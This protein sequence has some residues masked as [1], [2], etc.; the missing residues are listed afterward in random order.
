VILGAFL[1]EVG[2][3]VTTI[4]FVFTLGDTAFLIAVPI[5]CLVV[6]FVIARWLCRKIE[7]GFAL[8]GMLMGIVAT[9]MYFGL[10]Y[11]SGGSIA[12]AVETY[13]FVMFVVVNILR[14]VSAVAGGAAAGK[15]VP[16]RMLQPQA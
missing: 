2:L 7:S 12:S 4:P 13:G 5:A 1:I 9:V 8:H 14:I 10:I 11:G 15:R 6:P 16:K 3:I